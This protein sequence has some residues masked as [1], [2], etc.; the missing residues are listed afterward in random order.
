MLF[1][2]CDDTNEYISLN[3]SLDTNVFDDCAIENKPSEYKSKYQYKKYTN[4]EFIKVI[5][6]EI[7]TDNP[8]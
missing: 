7:Y 4:F 6:L 2:F 5:I 3:P 8:K 1:L